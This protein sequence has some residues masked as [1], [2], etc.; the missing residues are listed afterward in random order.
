[1]P[2]SS[3]TR[4]CIFGG[5]LWR[6]PGHRIEPLHGILVE[7]RR[8]A[9]L[10]APNE[11]A[12][13]KA[14]AG[15]SFDA[16]GGLVTPPMFDG[17]VHSSSTLLRG[18][19]NSYPLE[20]W[21]YHSI[22]YGRGFRE[23]H[24]HAAI[25][26]TA[27]E[28]IRSGIGGYIDHSPQSKLATTALEAHRQTGLRVGFAPFFADLL[29]EHILAIPLKAD[30]FL[31]PAPRSPDAIRETFST[32]HTLSAR[33]DRI[34]ILLG[35]NAP[36]RCSPE[37]WATWREL[38][39]EFGF[40]SHTH[41]LETLPQALHCAGKWPGGLVAELNRQGLLHDR[42][43]VAHGVWLDDADRALLARRGTTVVHNPISNAMLGS[44]RFDM[45]RSLDA[46]VPLAL[47]TDSTNT[48]GRHDLFETMRHM[49]VAGRHAGS[50]YSRWVTPSEAFATATGGIRALGGDN[51][52]GM[53]SAGGPADLLMIDFASH[54]LAGAQPSVDALVAHGDP[55]SV[56][57]L[58][59]D[60]QWLLR[61]GRIEVFDEA[62][63]NAEAAECAAE[64]RAM[65]REAAADLSALAPDYAR[66][67]EAFF[68]DQTCV[69]CGQPHSS[70]LFGRSLGTIPNRETES[71][72]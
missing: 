3:P 59:V 24:L 22:N 37:L 5:H 15:H 20:L 13:A 42:V 67:H 53:I 48:S 39:G 49:L 62:A 2:E 52:L 18:T 1:M 26:L 16:T 14:G 23:R 61:D 6:G 11:V 27:I 32:L 58:M 69:E 46:G 4:T 36:Q 9:G 44:G 66:W 40:G 10:L 54:S 12:K 7:D 64:L 30:R 57:A 63:A 56:K 34:Q 29:D 68:R 43:S 38:Q 70:K 60:G 51:R 25:R 28:M 35:P 47:G 31:P 33:E 72:L 71:N 21:A 65:G 8:I 41:L 19:E 17:H 45:R 50:D 55:R